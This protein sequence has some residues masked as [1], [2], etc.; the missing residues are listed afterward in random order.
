M[1]L[2][3][4]RV[5]ELLRTSTELDIPTDSLENLM[6]KA[7]ISCL[8]TQVVR[9]SSLRERRSSTIRMVCQLIGM[10]LSI[11]SIRICLVIL[12]IPPAF[13]V[14]AELLLTRMIQ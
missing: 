3:L 12:L 14:T 7:I 5:P 4:S 6:K 8:E 9:V 10:V 11:I 2:V 1:S 13:M